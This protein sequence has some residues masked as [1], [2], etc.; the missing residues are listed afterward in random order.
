[1]HFIINNITSMNIEQKVKELKGIVSDDYWPWFA[2]YLVVKRAA[3][4]GYGWA[5]LRQGLLGGRREQQSLLLVVGRAAQV[6]GGPAAALLP[7]LLSLPAGPWLANCLAGERAAQVPP[8]L[9][10][11]LLPSKLS[12]S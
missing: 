2:N 4:V 12:L 10:G 3:Q 8:P 7:R 1:M 9:G 5:S 6:R 11:L